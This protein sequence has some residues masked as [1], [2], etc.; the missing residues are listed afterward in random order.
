M[1]MSN[2]LYMLK[3]DML[4]TCLCVGVFLKDRLTVGNDFIIM[5]FVVPVE[6]ALCEV[7]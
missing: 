3:W 2:M 5:S 6:I 7:R 1:Y 4:S